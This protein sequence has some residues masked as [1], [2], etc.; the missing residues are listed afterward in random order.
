[1]NEDIVMKT[2][3]TETHCAMCRIDFLETGVCPSGKKHGFVAYWPQG[4]IEIY[5]ALQDGILKPTQ[6]LIDI[7]DTCT[8]CGICDKQCSE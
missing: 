2:V 7:A 5:Q 8:L 6:Q 4:R 1:M 3:N